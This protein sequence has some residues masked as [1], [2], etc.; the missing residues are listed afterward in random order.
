MRSPKKQLPPTAEARASAQGTC[1][2]C[3]TDS[4]ELRKGPGRWPGSGFVLDFQGFAGISWGLGWA[5]ALW[6]A[7]R[8]FVVVGKVLHSLAARRMRSP[9]KHARAPTHRGSEGIRPG[10]LCKVSNGLAGA[11]ERARALA[12]LGF[13]MAGCRITPV[14]V[15]WT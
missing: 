2:R 11:Q 10:H 9:K 1:V 8:T 4:L 6:W 15:F 14:L 13:C 7:L 12:W 3:P 5:R